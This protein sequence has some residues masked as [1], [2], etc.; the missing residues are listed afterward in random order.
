MTGTGGARPRGPR[1]GPLPAGTAAVVPGAQARS[2]ER[3]WRSP[4]SGGAGPGHRERCG[5]LG[6]KNTPKCLLA[7][8]DSRNVFH[9]SCLGMAVAVGSSGRSTWRPGKHLNKRCQKELELLHNEICK[10]PTSNPPGLSPVQL[11]WTGHHGQECPILLE[12]HWTRMS[13]SLYAGKDPLGDRQSLEGAD[14][15]PRALI[16]GVLFLGIAQEPFPCPE[17]QQVPQIPRM[18]TEKITGI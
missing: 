2:R 1:P 4:G 7:L 9:G 16:P 18:D 6:A 10:N 15:A 14:W 5:G 8:M 13:F 17:E 12:M 11:P 3:R